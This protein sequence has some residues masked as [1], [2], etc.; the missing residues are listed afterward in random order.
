MFFEADRPLRRLTGDAVRLAKGE[1]ERMSEDAYGGKFGS[2]ARSVNIHIDKLGREAKAAKQDLGQM[3]G[4]APEGGLGT[5]DLLATALPSVRP[6][7]PAPAVPQPPS[8]FRF[9]D[10]GPVQT[11]VRKAPVR[12]GTPPPTRPGTPPPFRAATPPAGVPVPP[13]TPPPRPSQRM[14]APPAP[15]TP[16][17]ASASASVSNL[18]AVEAPLEDEGTGRTTIMPAPSGPTRV[19]PH[20]KQVFEQ[21]IATKKTCNEPTTGLVYERFAEKLV[22]NR[23]DLIAKTGCREVRFTVYVKDGKAALKATPV[24]DE[25]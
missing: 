4:P 14:S 1:T 12:P 23:D 22:K 21:F 20:F 25:A 8:D 6:G 2:I 19:D 16:A 11:T 24:K 17:S 3:L 7:G 10:S 18:F 15:M 9:Q 5:I 13:A